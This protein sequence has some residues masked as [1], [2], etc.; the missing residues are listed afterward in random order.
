MERAI[1]TK[2]DLIL[3]L[4]P[5]AGC[6]DESDIACP[7][8][9]DPVP[10][11]IRVSDPEITVHVPDTATVTAFVYD[12]HGEIMAA[13]VPSWISRD[14][15]TATVSATG[16]VGAVASGD[17]WVVAVAAGLTDSVFVRVRYVVGA[18]EARVRVRGPDGDG[19]QA[20][21]PWAWFHDLLGTETRDRF[22][23]AF[24]GADT[25][26]A[27]IL[28][29]Y[30]TRGNTQMQQLPVDSSTLTTDLQGA[31]FSLFNTSIPSQEIDP[32]LHYVLRSPEFQ[33][34]NNV[35]L[36]MRINFTQ[37][38]LEKSLFQVGVFVTRVVKVGTP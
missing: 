21:R 19:E 22:L 20:L 11:Q 31:G 32:T 35:D 24:D 37:D 8:K 25:V 9:M 36:G 7:R 13:L 17:T 6:G 15:S 3:A 30:P 4:I 34:P 29:G 10:T 14:P 18:G 33:A 26:I 23:L 1:V 12:Q 2:L 16:S 28:P 5:L 38:A 27:V